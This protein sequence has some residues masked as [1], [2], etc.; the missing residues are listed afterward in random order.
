MAIQ[1]YINEN[2]KGKALI[3]L[4]QVQTY[5]KNTDVTITGFLTNTILNVS[6]KFENYCGTTL[7]SDSF[8]GVYTC[9]YQTGAIYPRN[10]PIISISSIDYKQMGSSSNWESLDLTYVEI[11]HPR[12]FNIT[13]TYNPLNK[14]QVKYTAGYTTVP[15]DIQQIAIEAVFDAYQNSAIGGSKLGLQSSNVSSGN[16]YGEV[17]SKIWTDHMEVLDEYKVS[18]I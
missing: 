13:H 11:N 3:T 15:N 6:S 16:S 4:Q 12:Y 14:Y 10:V 1:N 9:D 17:Y 7:A 18:V 2:P 8:T 5:M